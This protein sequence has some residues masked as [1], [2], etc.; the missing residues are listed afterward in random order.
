MSEAEKLAV[1]GS[2]H[3]SLVYTDYQRQGQARGAERRWSSKSGSNLLFTLLLEAKRIPAPP[4]TIP[5]LAGLGVCR[6]LEELGLSPQ[7]KW[8]ND[9]LLEG[10]KTAGILCR[11]YKG[12]FLIGTG[13]NCNQRDFPPFPTFPAVSIHTILGR[14]VNRAPLLKALLLQ[15]RES[16]NGD[17][18]EQDIPPRLYGRKQSVGFRPGGPQEQQVIRGTV[19]GIDHRGCLRFLPTGSDQ[20]TLFCAGE[21]VP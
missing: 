7:I 1:E 20:E 15:L 3:G 4:E 17:K 9:I 19:T 11:R 5:L 2:P 18:W 16:I 12:Y 8:P 14:P 10:G 21:I 6:A 13:L